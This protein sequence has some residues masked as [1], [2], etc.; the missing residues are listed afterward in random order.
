[1]LIPAKTRYVKDQAPTW[2]LTG[3]TVPVEISVHHRGSAMP[4]AATT[5]ATGGSSLWTE[6]TSKKALWVKT[7]LLLNLRLF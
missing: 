6:G 1:V 3:T 7:S 2:G 4:V 5:L